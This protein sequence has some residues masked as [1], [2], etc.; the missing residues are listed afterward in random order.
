MVS[1]AGNFPLDQLLVDCYTK[2]PI[3]KAKL[4]PVSETSFP[5]ITALNN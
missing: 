5:P 2:K 1:T 3:H 4:L